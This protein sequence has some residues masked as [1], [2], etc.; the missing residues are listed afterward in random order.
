M[1]F[2]NFAGCVLSLPVYFDNDSHAC[3]LSGTSRSVWI[4]DSGATDHITSNKDIFF[5]LT[6]LTTPY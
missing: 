4:I 6:P 2:A 5:N 1:A 3:L